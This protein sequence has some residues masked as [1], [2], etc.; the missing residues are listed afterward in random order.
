MRGLEVYS[1]HEVDNL[2][3]S[4]KIVI[5]LSDEQVRDF[6]DK[7]LTGAFRNK[8]LLLGKISAD[9]ARRIYDK[10]GIDFNGYNLELRSNEIK[11]TYKEHGDKKTEF[12]RGQQAITAE[13][14]AKFSNIVSDFDDVL[15]SYYNSLQF[16]KDINGRTTAVTIYADG[17][18]SITLKTMYKSRKSGA[19]GPTSNAINGGKPKPGDGPDLGHN[20]RDGWTTGSATDNI[21]NFKPKSKQKK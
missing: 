9:L 17:N 12:P 21:G 20:V 1:E 19:S 15:L 16:I 4:N 8:K 14:I 6:V 7:S 3:G 11:H 13:D 10:T 18:K 2:R 5:A